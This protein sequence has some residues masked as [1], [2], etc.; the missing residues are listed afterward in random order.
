M[1]FKL[2]KK[3]LA[4]IVLILVALAALLWVTSGRSRKLKDY[5]GV[6]DETSSVISSVTQEQMMEDVKEQVLQDN[7]DLKYSDLTEDLD[8]YADYIDGGE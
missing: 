5:G 2:N 1:K 4:V 7:P 6:P 8:Y 3:T